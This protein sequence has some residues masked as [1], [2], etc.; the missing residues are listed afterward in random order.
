[1]I[2]GLAV[3]DRV[4]AGGVVGDHAADRRPVRGGDVGG[5]LQAVRLDLLVQVVE[6]AARL[7]ASQRSV[8]VDL[9]DAV[10]ILRAVEDHARPDRLAGLRRA[11]A[12]GRSGTPKRAHDADRGDDVGL[13]R[14]S[15]TP[16]G[17]IW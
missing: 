11:A 14:G 6:H 7:D 8:G 3:D 17:T 1:M 13:V 9:Q 2:D 15:T 12:A 4:R 16:S 10:E 5:E